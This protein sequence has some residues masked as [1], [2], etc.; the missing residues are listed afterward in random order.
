MR[1]IPSTTA[2]GEAINRIDRAAVE[3]LYSSS[4]FKYCVKAA[5]QKKLYRFINEELLKKDWLFKLSA[6]QRKSGKSL[7]TFL[8]EQPSL[9]DAIGEL[10]LSSAYSAM[11]YIEAYYLIRRAIEDKLIQGKKE[12]QIAFILPN[13][14]GKYYLDLEKEIGEM[15]RLDFGDSIAE[16]KVKITFQ[17]FLYGD[18]LASRP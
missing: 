12:S 16:M 17:F 7:Y 13:D 5:D 10:D 8:N 2:L 9:F 3:C 15:L 6:H 11:Q 18:S 4:F 1:K 14:E